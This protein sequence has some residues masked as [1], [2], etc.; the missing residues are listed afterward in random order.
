MPRLSSRMQSIALIYIDIPALR[1]GTVG[2]YAFAFLCAGVAIA[3]RIALEPYV[4][5]SAFITAYPAVVITSLISGLGAGVFC[6]VLAAAAAALFV[7]SPQFSFYVA[8]PDDVIT[9]LLFILVSL[10]NVIFISGMRF[11]VGRYREQSVAL[12]ESQERLA[13]VVAELQHRTRNLISVVGTMAKGTLR[14]SKTFD[15][16]IAIFQDRLEVL[17]RAQGLLF[18]TEGRNRVTFD[19]LIETELCAQSIPMEDG[20]VTLDGPKGIPLRSHTVQ[21]L[22]MALHE[23]MTNAIKYGALKQPNGRLTIRW[24]TLVESGKLWLHLDWKESGVEMP[25]LGAGPQGSGQGRELIERVLPYQFDAQT[26]FAMEADGVHCTISL[27]ASEHKMTD[28]PG[29]L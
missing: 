25:P 27:P 7:V 22:A 15:E 8:H 2:A 5:G 10:V 14:T 19:E 1:P 18:R 26:T 23:L 21:S 4:V 11:A 28:H 12:R 16:F 9:I 24:E 13:S 3:V 20:P 6:T 17:G 29:V